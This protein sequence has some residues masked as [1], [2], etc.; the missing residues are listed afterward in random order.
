MP[1]VKS[2]KDYPTACDMTQWKKTCKK[3]Y[4]IWVCMP[5]LGTKVYNK[6]EDSHY[7]TNEKR[8]FV[9][10]GTFG[11]QWI[12]DFDKLV[13]TYKFPDGTPIT[14]DAL[15]KKGHPYTIEWFKIETVDD[16]TPQWAFHVEANLKLGVETSWGDRLIANRAGVPHGFGDYIVC[17]DVCGYPN[18]ND[19]WVVNGEVFPRTYNMTA[20]KGLAI[21]GDVNPPMPPSLIK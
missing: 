8:P 18:M 5:K 13:K 11:E 20:F 14:L 12:V 16:P 4:Q 10:S 15:K 2:W 19:V 21:K 17:T 3:K 6:L 7:E 1:P 9:L